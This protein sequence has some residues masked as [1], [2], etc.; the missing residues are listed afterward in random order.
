MEKYF[1]KTS[2]YFVINP[3]FSRFSSDIEALKFFGNFS[4]PDGIIKLIWNLKCNKNKRLKM[5]HII[6]GRRVVKNGRP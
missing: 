4:R 5:K 1:F 3:G 2:V 6:T